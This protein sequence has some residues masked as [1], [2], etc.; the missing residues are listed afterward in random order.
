MVGSDHFYWPTKFLKNSLNDILPFLQF[1]IILLYNSNFSTS[2]LEGFHH[3]VPHHCSGEPSYVP[4]NM[5]F[6]SQYEGMLP[7]FLSV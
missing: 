6:H 3:Y 7:C 1:F 4:H 5:F 2:Q